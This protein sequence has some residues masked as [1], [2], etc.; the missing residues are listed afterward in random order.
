MEELFKEV[1][2]NMEGID[3]ISVIIKFILSA[4]IGTLIAFQGIRE[5]SDNK[6]NI[7]VKIAKSK[8]L[9]CITGAITVV[10]IGNS[11]AKAIGLFGI[12]S[13]IRFRTTIEDPVD[14]AVMF[15]LIILGM[16]IGQELYL[17]AFILA[18]FFYTTLVVMSKIKGLK[19]VIKIKEN[20]VKQ[21]E[22]EKIEEIKENEGAATIIIS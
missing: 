3:F 1:S 12:G 10:I 14:S 21:P 6:K 17:P 22:R 4:A 11:M 16:A 13:F 20:E 19:K 18:L 5:N 8:I 9:I 7:D 2:L 15:I